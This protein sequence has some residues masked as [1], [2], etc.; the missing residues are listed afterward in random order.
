MSPMGKEF[1]SMLQGKMLIKV[2]EMRNKMTGLKDKQVK[3]ISSRFLEGGW[4]VADE[5]MKVIYI[6]RIQIKP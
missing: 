6:R 3:I 2:P 1:S 5:V 4:P